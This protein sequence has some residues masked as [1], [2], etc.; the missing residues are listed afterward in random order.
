MCIFLFKSLASY[1]ALSF[2]KCRACSLDKE[3]LVVRLLWV[4]CSDD[5]GL[6][7]G[8]LPPW[9]LLSPVPNLAS[10]ASQSLYFSISKMGIMIFSDRTH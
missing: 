6:A 5:R 3:V 10:L 4:K 2:R 7:L 8:G 1:H 9:V